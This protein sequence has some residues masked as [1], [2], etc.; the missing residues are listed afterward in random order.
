MEKEFDIEAKKDE[1]TPVV[2]EHMGL[3]HEKSQKVLNEN[4][5]STMTVC[6]VTDLLDKGAYLGGVTMSCTGTRRNRFEMLYQLVKACYSELIK[7]TNEGYAKMLWNSFSKQVVAR[8][9]YFQFGWSEFAEELLKEIG[10]KFTEDSDEN[11][12]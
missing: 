1:L 5:L 9:E 2:E 7:D 4:G 12:E 10:K 11:N 8:K 3:I 6:C